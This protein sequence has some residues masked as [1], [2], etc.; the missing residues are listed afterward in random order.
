MN[1]VLS[2][3][4]KYPPKRWILILCLLFVIPLIIIVILAIVD[5]RR[6]YLVSFVVG[7][8]CYL[9][10]Y[11]WYDVAPV[12]VQIKVGLNSTEVLVK[13]FFWT[14]RYEFKHDNC[15]LYER[16]RKGVIKAVGLVSK[17]NGKKWVL[18][19]K[20]SGWD[21][22]SLLLISETLKKDSRVS[23]YGLPGIDY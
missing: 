15:M 6:S 12:P 13:R 3:S 14:K 10:S 21:K 1:E 19:S 5:E 16:Q 20:K 4:I 7:Y 18:F 17:T 8:I 2:L 9:L 23:K 22:K 11:F